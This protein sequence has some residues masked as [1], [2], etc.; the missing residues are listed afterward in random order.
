MSHH[1]DTQPRIPKGHPEGGEWVEKA[2]QEAHMAFDPRELSD[3]EY[4]KDGSFEYPPKA[5]SAAQ[6]L[7]FWSR[8]EVPDSILEGAKAVWTARREL[9][10][11]T[12]RKQYGEKIRSHENEEFREYVAFKKER[13]DSGNV[14]GEW[15]DQKMAAYHQHYPHYIR[16]DDIRTILRAAHAWWQAQDLPE[17]EKA[18]VLGEQVYLNDRGGYSITV[19]KCEQMYGFNLPQRNFRAKAVFRDKSRWALDSVEQL[20]DDLDRASRGLL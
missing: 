12:V 8:V 15:L 2:G 4:N 17:D 3:E 13:G 20:R 9:E 16:D 11:D 1:S 7:A 5:R 6:V 19:D 18:Q 14:V 10:D